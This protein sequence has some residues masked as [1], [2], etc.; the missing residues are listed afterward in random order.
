M[1]VG[2]A[3]DHDSG[4]LRLAQVT[5]AQRHAVALGEPDEPGDGPM[6]Q[7]RIGRMRN[8]LGLHFGIDHHPFQVLGTDS[9]QSC[10]PPTDFP[11]S[12]DELL[13][14]EPP[15]PARHRRSIE[16]QPVAKTQ[17]AAEVLVIGVLDPAGA[18]HLIVETAYVLQNEQAGDKPRRQTRLPRTGLAHEPKRSSRNSQSISAASRASGW[19]MSMI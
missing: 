18:Q 10:A 1:M 7:P 15:A 8:G 2:V 13:L 6:H 9:R 14:A 17:L 16:R 5:L 11:G 3:A 4:A 19:P 12:G